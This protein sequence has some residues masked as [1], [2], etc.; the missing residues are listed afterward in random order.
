MEELGI[1]LANPKNADAA[2]IVID[3][4]TH[5]EGELEPEVV[6]AVAEVWADDGVQACFARSRE[7]QLNDSAS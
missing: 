5:V 4:P 2:A 7:Y 1:N 6:R 3:L